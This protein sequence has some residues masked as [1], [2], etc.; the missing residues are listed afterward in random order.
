MSNKQRLTVYAMW[1]YQDD[2]FSG[3]KAPA[4]IS[5]DDMIHTIVLTCGEFSCLYTQPEFFR[6]AISSWC[7]V[8][9]SNWERILR[10]LTEE[11]NPIENADRHEDW[12]DTRIP[13]L[14]TEDSGSFANN[15]Q[16]QSTES[17]SSSSY[18]SDVG[19]NSGSLKDTDR[20][21]GSTSGSMSATQT[22]AGTQG[23]INILT[24]EDVNKHTGRVHGNIGVTTNQ[25]MIN[26][27]I[28]LRTTSAFC[29]IIADQ[30]KQQFCL[31]IY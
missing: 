6:D 8:W 17:S 28:D 18:H 16:S 1:K 23:N 7:S 24:G 11:Y 19:Y 30:F 3:L 31:M 26:E 29:Q 25:T 14:R 20:D 27:E 9:Y 22:N 5:K 13:D 4:G 12:V 15:S 10:A 2:L 21:S